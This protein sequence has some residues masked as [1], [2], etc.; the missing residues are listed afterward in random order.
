MFKNNEGKMSS[1]NPPKE[2]N[3]NLSE[4]FSKG[5]YCIVNIA[6]TSGMVFKFRMKFM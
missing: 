6:T 2:K 1:L 5:L 4:I 3:Y